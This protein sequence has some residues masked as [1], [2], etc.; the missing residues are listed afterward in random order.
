MEGQRLPLQ[1]PKPPESGT[2]LGYRP[3]LRMPTGRHCI[4]W[5]ASFLRQTGTIAGQLGEDCLNPSLT[6]HS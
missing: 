4:S 3:S 1:L 2:D 6:T 5:K